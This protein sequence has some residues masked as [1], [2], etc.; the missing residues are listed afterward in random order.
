MCAFGRYGAPVTWLEFLSA[1]IGQLIW[2]IF[3]LVVVLLLKEPIKQLASNPRL[4]RVKAGPGGLEVELRDELEQAAK[5]L[6]PAAN[7]P[8]PKASTAD[9]SVRMDFMAEMTRL[10][11]VSPRSV[12]LESHAQLE[13]LLRN[14]VDVPTGDDRRPRYLSMRTLTRAATS[15]GLLTQQEAGALDELTFLRNRVAHEPDEEITKETALRYAELSAELALA[16]RLGMGES[17]RDG[18]TL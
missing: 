3:V 17:H 18:P 8:A 7:T 12:V 11:A 1:T 2:P 16:V 5:E 6:E 14:S 13:K 15:Q 10:A 4:K 9:E